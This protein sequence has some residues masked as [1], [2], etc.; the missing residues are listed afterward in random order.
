MSEH[1]EIFLKNI[2]ISNYT[3]IY[4]ISSIVGK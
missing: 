1:I 3:D 2:V 4:M